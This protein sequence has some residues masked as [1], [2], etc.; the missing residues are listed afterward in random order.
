[1]PAPRGPPSC[2][3]QGESALGRSRSRSPSTSVPSWVDIPGYTPDVIIYG[4]VNAV[5]LNGQPGMFEEIMPSGRL[6]VRLLSGEHVQ[7]DV[8]NLDVGSHWLRLRLGLDE[9]RA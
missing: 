3:S 6:R 5:H 1:M 8:R 2:S 9:P 7:V 4:L